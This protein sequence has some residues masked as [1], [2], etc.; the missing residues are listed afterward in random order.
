VA[1]VVVPTPAGFGALE[2]ALRYVFEL[3]YSLNA[4]SPTPEQI[5]SA[6]TAGLRTAIL[7]RL[8]HLTIALVGVGFY[9]A[10]RRE[11]EEV[12]EEE[13]H[14]LDEDYQPQPPEDV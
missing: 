12:L 2:G 6:R 14:V 8:T 7:F 5:V 13:E 10:T 1:G 11:I 4:S 3:S 9:L